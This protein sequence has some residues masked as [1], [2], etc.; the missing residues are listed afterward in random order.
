MVEDWTNGRDIIQDLSDS[1]TLIDFKE[2]RM[3]IS[4]YCE[5][6]TISIGRLNKIIYKAEDRLI[7]NIISE[8]STKGYCMY[9]DIDE[10]D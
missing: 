5:R 4:S 7:E 2:S 9:P 3:N 6:N 10:E 1:L 8:L